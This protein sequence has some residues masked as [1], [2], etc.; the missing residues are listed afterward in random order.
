M[1][2]PVE[3]ASSANH[4]CLVRPLSCLMR[5]I[6]ASAYIAE[7]SGSPCVVPSHEEIVSP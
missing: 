4:N 1:S 2:F 6:V 5:G 3:E 7:A